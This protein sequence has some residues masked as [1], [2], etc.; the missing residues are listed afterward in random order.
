MKGNSI[1]NRIADRSCRCGT[2]TWIIE[3][4]INNPKVVI[5]CATFNQRLQLEDMIKRRIRKM[6]RIKRWFWNKK[7]NNCVPIVASAEAFVRDEAG[8]KRP[9]ILDNSVY[10]MD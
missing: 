3:A 9:V 4:A 10:Y 8:F 2:T 6:G 5:V 1:I 7:H